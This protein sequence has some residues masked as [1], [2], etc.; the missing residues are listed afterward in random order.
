MKNLHEYT[1]NFYG[2]I[3]GTIIFGLAILLMNIKLTFLESFEA[4]DFVYLLSMSI[5]NAFSIVAKTIS[6]KYG[7]ASRT[8][9]LSYLSILLTLFIDIVFFG[10][11]FSEQQSIG[12]LIVIMSI[13]VSVVVVFK[14]NN[15]N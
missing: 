14:K 2:A 11:S 4:I 13:V 3:A 6:L 8:S 9:I 1:V 15:K 10:T 5:I 7:M 12:L